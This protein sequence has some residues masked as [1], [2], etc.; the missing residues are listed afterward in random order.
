MMSTYS[1]R[2][3]ENQTWQ[4]T[5]EMADHLVG[6]K[7]VPASS[8]QE[9]NWYSVIWYIVCDSIIRKIKSATVHA[10]NATLSLSFSR[11]M[12]TVHKATFE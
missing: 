7:Q 2:F 6:I 9:L 4:S 11:N 3:D 1:F 12:Y 10:H 5:N 8:K